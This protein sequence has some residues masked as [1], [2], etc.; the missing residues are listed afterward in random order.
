MNIELFGEFASEEN[1][2]YLIKGDINGYV[3]IEFINEQFSGNISYCKDINDRN[4]EWTQINDKILY[5]I[6][7]KRAIKDYKKE[8]LG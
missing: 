1:L 5:N 4:E 6:I 7:K 3:D 2:I 8:I